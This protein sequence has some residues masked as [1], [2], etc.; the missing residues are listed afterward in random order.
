M[1]SYLLYTQLYLN[2]LLLQDIAS[3]LIGGYYNNKTYRQFSDTYVLGR[4][5]DL[6]RRQNTDDVRT[7][8]IPIN[9]RPWISDPY[10]DKWRG[11][12]TSPSNISPNIQRNSPSPPNANQ[13][14]LNL[15]LVYDEAFLNYDECYKFLEAKIDSINEET[16]SRSYTIFSF[17]NAIITLMYNLCLVKI[18]DSNINSLVNL[19]IG[20]YVLF[21]GTLR[22]NTVSNYIDNLINILNSYGTTTLDTK[23]DNTSLGPITYS[24]M[25]K[26]LSSIQ[27]EVQKRKSTYVTLH[28]PGINALLSLSETYITPETLL[29]D[30]NGSTVV[31]F[32]K[33][34]NIILNPNTR[35]SVFNKTGL[36]EYYRILLDSF[37]PYLQVLNENGYI[38]PTEYISS[39]P[40]PALQL[41]PISIYI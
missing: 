8:D 41:I 19:S 24:M 7:S 34:S 3:E 6:K 31:A 27:A 2:T 14:D 25:V 21:C 5:Q 26:L 38:V 20:N 4:E 11:G 16:H 13:S 30:S 12:I 40:G 29:Y 39:I 32:C 36:P 33:I 35:I 23:F 37:T 17:Y 1:S 10:Y 28:I 15:K 18:I 9:F 22:T